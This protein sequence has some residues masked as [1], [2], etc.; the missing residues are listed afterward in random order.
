MAAVQLARVAV[1]GSA[2]AALL[3][4]V[5]PRS[6]S[7]KIDLQKNAPFCAVTRPT[8]LPPIA[9]AS[10]GAEQPQQPQQ[11]AH[12]PPNSSGHAQVITMPHQQALTRAARERCERVASD[13]RSTALE[14]RP[15]FADERHPSLLAPPCSLEALLVPPDPPALRPSS[16]SP[17]SM[18]M[19]NDLMACVDTSAYAHVSARVRA[20]PRSLQGWAGQ[21]KSR[22]GQDECR[23]HSEI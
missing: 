16:S 18:V 13:E 3:G 11:R 1:R 14:G 6:T 22:V 5:P 12:A 10:L 21:D 9:F 23:L 7:T 20:C 8:P 2:D 4:F 15:R 17:S 19:A